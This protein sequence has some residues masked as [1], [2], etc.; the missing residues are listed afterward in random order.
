MSCNTKVSTA[1]TVNYL[2]FVTLVNVIALC[3]TIFVKNI[4]IIPVIVGGQ[5]KYATY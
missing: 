2:L 1:G 3:H 4:R 5:L